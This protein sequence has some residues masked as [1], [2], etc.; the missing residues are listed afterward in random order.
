LRDFSVSSSSSTKPCDL[1][2]RSAPSP[3]SSTWFVRRITSSATFDGVLML[4]SDATAPA[5]WVG[6]SIT[7]ASS[8]TTPSAF[9]SPP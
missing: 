9:G 6:P 5:R 2:N 3:T 7:A 1:A 8:S 4:W